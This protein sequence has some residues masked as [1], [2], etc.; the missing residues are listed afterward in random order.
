VTLKAALSLPLFVTVRKY[1]PVPKPVG[2]C[3]TAC[4]FVKEASP[5]WVC[6]KTTVGAR[7][8]GL[9]LLPVIVIWLLD[10][11]TTVL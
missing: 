6:A 1:V 8:D 9:K 4:W 11:F 7:P 3:A 2:R 5:R 10:V